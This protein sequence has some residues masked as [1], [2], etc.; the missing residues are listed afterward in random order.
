MHSVRLCA[1]IWS[2]FEGSVYEEVKI[3][4]AADRVRIETSCGRRVQILSRGELSGI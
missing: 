3:Y 1:S 2:L 4:G